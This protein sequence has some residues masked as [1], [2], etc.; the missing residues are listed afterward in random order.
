MDMIDDS[1][2]RGFQEDV[3]GYYRAHGRGGL[4]W[5]ATTDAY[6]IT[7]SELM[8]QQTQVGRVIPKY[9]AFLER[10]PTVDDLATAPLGDVLR[11]WSGLGYNRRAKF[12]WQAAQQVVRDHGG[13]FPDQTEALVKLPGIGR[14]TAAAIVAYAYDRPVIF[15]E[16]NI[17][18][19]FIH[20]FFDDQA[21][22]ADKAILELVGETL[23]KE[24]PRE[25]YWALM[26][27]GSH[28]KREVGNLSRLSRTYTKQ[29]AF[30]GSKRQIRGQVLRLLGEEPLTAAQL[31]ARIKDERL[32]D[33]LAGL[34]A[35]QLVRFKAGTYRL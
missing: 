31:H 34:V 2:R 6:R 23:D 22:I 30:H 11:A 33:V 20:H 12:L 10:F 9:H 7:V 17:R 21:D 28:L 1:V 26:D 8:L 27:Y 14:N 24:H 15:V 18:T 32:T 3:W 29:S 13:V 5:R 16:T 35:E 19:V 4:P 25:W